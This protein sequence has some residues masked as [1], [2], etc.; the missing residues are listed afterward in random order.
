M[1]KHYFFDYNDE[2]C[3]SKDRVIAI[4]KESEMKEATLFEAKIVKNSGFFYCINFQEVGESGSSGCGKECVEY[5]P[6]NGKNGR[7]KYSGQVYEK[8]DKKVTFKQQ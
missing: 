2:E 3:Y 1:G 4:M 6:R 7:C 8:T 5:T